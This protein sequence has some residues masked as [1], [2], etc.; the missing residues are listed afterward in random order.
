MCWSQPVG[1][2]ACGWTGPWGSQGDCSAPSA[3]AIRELGKERSVTHRSSRAHG[4][5]RGQR[6]HR[7]RGE[8]VDLGLCLCQG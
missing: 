1:S 6:G 4:V 2:Q 3:T 8:S 7:S 5:P